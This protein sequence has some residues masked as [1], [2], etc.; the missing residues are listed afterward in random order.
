MPKKVTVEYVT[1]KVR[2]KALD[3]LS[4]LMH[5]NENKTQSDFYADGRVAEC[6]SQVRKSIDFIYGAPWYHSFPDVA[7]RP[8]G[9]YKVAAVVLAPRIYKVEPLDY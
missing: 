5:F 2:V 3:S 6:P 1:L 8:D 4:F 7:G 9:E